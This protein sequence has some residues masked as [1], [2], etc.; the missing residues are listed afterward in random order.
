VEVLQAYSSRGRHYESCLDKILVAKEKTHPSRQMH[1]LKAKS[2]AKLIH[3]LT[4]KQIAEM[5]AR[6]RQGWSSRRLAKV[7]GVSKTSVVILL[8][9]AGIPIRRQG[10]GD[11]Q[12]DDVIQ[13]YAAGASLAVI[14]KA[15][16][17]SADT[18]RK[19]LIRQGTTLRRPWDRP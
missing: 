13:R 7:Y 17:V 18:I 5:T 3:R 8:R 12:A 4:S 6:Y 10:L 15:H 16:G 14:G 1:Q 2:S 11:C 9:D 19:L